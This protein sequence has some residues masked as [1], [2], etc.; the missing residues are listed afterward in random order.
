MVR[1]GRVLGALVALAS[2]AAHAEP[3]TVDWTKRVI[4]ATGQGAPDLNAANIAVARLGAERAAKLDALRNILETLKGVAISSG[5]TVGSVL[6]E[7]AVKA[8]VEGVCRGFKI[9]EPKRYFSDGGVEIDVEMPMDAVAG[10]LMDKAAPAQ[11]PAPAKPPPVDAPKGEAPKAP[12]NV[13]GVVVDARGLKAS[14]AF[15]P[16]LFDEAGAEVYGPAVVNREAALK[17]GVA[18]YA[19]DLGKAKGDERVGATALVVK[20]LR[21]A[22]AGKS[23][24]VISGADA[25]LLKGSGEALAQGKVIIVTD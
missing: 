11:P 24:L 23:D 1:I 20:A 15:A 9:L 12:A 21:L 18:G 16:R 22:N 13:T 3:G 19:N 4:K 10:V 17:T 8:Q 5:Q 14:P 2:F 7:P 25:G 6:N